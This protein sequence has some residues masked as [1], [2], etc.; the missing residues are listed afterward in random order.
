MF[1]GSVASTVEPPP[2]LPIDEVINTAEVVPSSEA[3]DQGEQR[4]MVT[5]RSSRINFTA[6]EVSGNYTAR[7]EREQD[8]NNMEEKLRNM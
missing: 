6:A 7:T 4:T 5:A 2:F 1:R 3:N 8:F